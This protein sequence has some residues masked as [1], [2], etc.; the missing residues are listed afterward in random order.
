MTAM[1]LPRFLASGDAARY[2]GVNSELFESEIKPMLEEVTICPGT[3]VFDRFDLDNW[4]DDIKRCQPIVVPQGS[5]APPRPDGLEQTPSLLT[6]KQ[7]ATKHKAF[8][9]GSLR[10]M[11]FQ[12]SSRKSSKGEIRGNG[13]E[14]ALVRLGRKILI[15]E[16]EFFKWLET[17]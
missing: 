1:L 5:S 6:V 14:S 9:E 13:L 10:S 3:K 4:A 15:D 16:S 12:A 2:L 7:F 8:T 17:R 11:I